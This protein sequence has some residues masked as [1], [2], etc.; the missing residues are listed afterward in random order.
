[1][2]KNI[3]TRFENPQRE[4]GRGCEALARSI[5]Q[6]DLGAPDEHIPLAVSIFTCLLPCDPSSLV[7]IEASSIS[8]SPDTS[9]LPWPFWLRLLLPSSIHIALFS[10]FLYSFFPFFPFSLSF[11]FSRPLPSII[12]LFK[13]LCCLLLVQSGINPRLSL[14]HQPVLCSHPIFCEPLKGSPFVPLPSACLRTRSLYPL[15]V[16]LVLRF[17]CTHL[18]GT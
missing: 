6:G 12:P 3:K 8:L 15:G 13:L 4:F 10:F 14:P 2:N 11:L 9:F 18:S 17:R 1:M 16:L 5:K 7:V